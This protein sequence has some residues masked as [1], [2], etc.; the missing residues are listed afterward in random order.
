MRGW[1]IL[2]MTRMRKLKRAIKNLTV[3]WQ[4]ETVKST[5][6]SLQSIKSGPKVIINI[7][8]SQLI[9]INRE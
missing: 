5:H 1:I 6:D 3:W 4:R 8:Q 2:S 7:D 9:E